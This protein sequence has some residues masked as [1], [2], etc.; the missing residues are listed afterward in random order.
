MR[1]VKPTQKPVPS[2]DVKDLFFNSGKID[3]WV[4]SLQHEYTDRFG[5]CHKTAAGME[6]V[7]NQLVERFKIESEQALLAAGYAP[8]GTFQGGAEV[9]SR[10]GTVLWKLPDGDGDHYRWDGDLPKQVPAGSTPQST[11]GVGKGA[12]VS[13]ADASLRSD[14]KANSG[15]SII[16]TESGSSLQSVITKLSKGYLSE[17]GGDLQALVNSVTDVFIDEDIDITTDIII[18]SNTNIKTINGAK[19]I[20]KGG[21]LR[22]DKYHYLQYWQ[23]YSGNKQ[24]PITKDVVSN[25]NEVSVLSTA[26][27]EVGDKILLR[28]GYCDLWRVLETSPKSLDAVKVQPYKSE[29]AT[30]TGIEGNTL[31]VSSL[32]YNYT[33]VPKTYGFLDD[34]NALDRYSGLTRPSIT[35][36][37]YKNIKLDLEVVVDESHSGSIGEVFYTDGVYIDI[38]LLN[39]SKNKTAFNIR[40]SCGVYID[41]F[42]CTGSYGNALSISEGSCGEINSLTSKEWMGGA[43]TPFLIMLMSSFSI[44]K[45]S[46]SQ[47]TST[48]KSREYSGLYI[49]TCD[50][51]TVLCGEAVNISRIVDFSFSRGVSVNNLTGNNVDAAAGGYNSVFCEINTANLNGYYLADD[52]SGFYFNLLIPSNQIY[53]NTYSNIKRINDLGYGRVL[54][55]DC[56]NLYMDNVVSPITP[57]HVNILGKDKE[58]AKGLDNLI[59]DIINSNFYRVLRTSSYYD[60]ENEYNIDSPRVSMRK[61]TLSNELNLGEGGNPYDFYDIYMPTGDIKIGKTNF[62]V[63][64]SGIANSLNIVKSSENDI[65]TCIPRLKNLL[66]KEKPSGFLNVS[67]NLQSGGT[68]GK[69]FHNGAIITD[70]TTREDWINTGVRGNVVWAKR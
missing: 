23:D 29:I 60:S 48:T 46:S 10:N 38:T 64:L 34:E 57:L 53:G 19:L 58:H 62:G 36:L 49:N 47:K 4:N 63:T 15:A 52:K 54:I 33:L 45:F 13:V 42:S 50:G 70:V 9:V 24:I 22:T 1:E 2:S 21:R 14:I 35:R 41:N 25:K 59:C 32:K 65:Y 51:G 66:L 3:E 55:Q 68:V 37:L 26:G 12:W 61:T 31:L 16:G 28:N 44:T 18:P 7:F 40:S 69:Y 27:F 17:N 6:W 43:D 5:K 11:G 39:K 20:F 56:T 67:S 30:I 8:I